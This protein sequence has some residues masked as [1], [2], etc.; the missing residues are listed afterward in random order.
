MR[1]LREATDLAS[2]REDR[3][4]TREELLDGVS[5]VHGLISLVSD[6]IDDEVMDAAPELRV[7]SNYAV[8]VD[9]VDV[10]AATERRIPVT[11]TPDVLTDATADM[12]FGLLLAVARRIV[13]GHDL[14]RSRSWRGWAP[15]LLLGSDVG[16]TTLGLIGLG[17]IGRAMVRRGRGFGMKVLYWNRTRLTAAEEQELGVEYAAFEEVLRRA[18]FVSLHVASTPDTRHLIDAAALELLG[19]SGY[20]INTARGP[21]VDERALLEALAS[22]TIAGAGLDVYEHEP[23]IEEGLHDLP[24]VVLT[25]HLGSATLDTRTAM[26]DLAVRNLLAALAGERP[27]HVVNPEALE[28][29]A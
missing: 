5:G 14:V 2:N 3:V 9:N 7:I 22:G 23:E 26:G 29:E 12:A 15:L 4:L 27:P 20:L 18:R 19:E 11:N 25:P 13:E 6:R 1:T 21:I 10:A 8:G 28:P 16:G 24:N 17:R